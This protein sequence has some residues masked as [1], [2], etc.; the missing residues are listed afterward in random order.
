MSTT[1]KPLLVYQSGKYP[2]IGLIIHGVLE[3]GRSQSTTTYKITRTC[4]PGAEKNVEILTHQAIYDRMRKGRKG[5]VVCSKWAAQKRDMEQMA[6]TKSQDA[7]IEFA[8]RVDTPKKITKN[9]AVVRWMAA[10]ILMR[11]PK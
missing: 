11:A 6:K 1:K 7:Y 9:S 4:H 3:H 8:A 10:Q 5:C 2:E